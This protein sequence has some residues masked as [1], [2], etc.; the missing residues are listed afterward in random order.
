MGDQLPPGWACFHDPEGRP[1]FQ[2]TLNGI[3]QWEVPIAPAI[4]G[5]P[6]SGPEVG[7]APA[8]QEWQ[9]A[10]E[11]SSTGG[12]WSTQNTYQL[13]QLGEEACFQNKVQ[14]LDP[15]VHTSVSASV[16]ALNQGAEAVEA[17][18]CV[19]FSQSRQMYFLLWHDNYRE[20]AFNQLD[21][22]FGKSWSLNLSMPL[23]LEGQEER[24][25]GKATLLPRDRYDSV[26]RAVDALNAGE[27]AVE[28]GFC[29]VYSSS[30]QQYFLLW[31]IAKEEE[32]LRRFAG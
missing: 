5:F 16:E 30:W 32:A 22:D 23:C 14:Y 8:Q 13:C 9:P 25:H 4:V 17:A 3:T 24:F 28:E 10:P 31:L 12:G 7:Q 29:I 11:P 2:N 1:Y 18:Y 6:Q 21:L 15:A 27:V 26:E 19:M 20:A